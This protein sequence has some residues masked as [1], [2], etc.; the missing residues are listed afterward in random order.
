MKHAVLTL[1][2][3]K[4]AYIRMAVNLA[5]SFLVWHPDA[6]IA[7]V[8]ATDRPELVPS[9]LSGRVEVVELA[10]GQYGEGFSPKLHLDQITPSTSTLFIDADCLC[11]GP[12]E[13]IFERFAGK[14]V[15]VVGGPVSSGEWFG[16]VRSVCA[17]FELSSIPKFN[18]GIYY[19]ERGPTC[20]DVYRTARALESRYDAIGLVRLRGRPNDELLMAIA[21]AVH[22]QSA[23][24]DDGSIMADPQ[25]YPGRVA[26][27][28]LH[29][30][31]MLSNPAPPHSMHVAWNPLASAKP[32]VV[33][34]L[35]DHTTRHPYRRE[36]I[37]LALRVARQ[38]PTVCAD[39]AA[40]LCR[41][42]P[43]ETAR[44]AKDLLRP[45]Y[46]QIAGTRAVTVS[47]R[48]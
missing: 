43:L 42:L 16:D 36:E 45:A 3:G 35:G 21:M 9:D 39:V 19:L 13:S 22:G 28:V 23:V 48:I 41:S 4:P 31:A 24:P 32:L 17:Q 15:S 25:A 11:V 8:M 12:L 40:L 5:R 34:F 33:H 27:D 10:A 44:V 14:S 37:R 1:A 29:G 38:W 30:G 46:R 20:S 26:L 18:G 2:V 7:F 47:E 6:D